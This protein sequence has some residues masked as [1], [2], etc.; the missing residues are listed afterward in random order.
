MIA[1]NDITS[2]N[3]CMAK[4]LQ[5]FFFFSFPTNLFIDRKSNLIIPTKYCKT[6]FFFSLQ[7][8]KKKNTISE[9]E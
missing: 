9:I 7:K 3:N 6:I 5:Y 2:T 8:K 4:S 1:I